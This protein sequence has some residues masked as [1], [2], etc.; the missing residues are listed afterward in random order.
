MALSDNEIIKALEMCGNS[1]G[2]EECPYYDGGHFQNGKCSYN[3]GQDAFNL[4]NRQKAEIENLKTHNA[5]LKMANKLCKGWEERVKAETIKEF[6]ERF[7]NEI[8]ERYEDIAY[9]DLF[10]RV[11][12]NLVKEKVGDNDESTKKS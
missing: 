8:N 4:I 9:K 5:V 6:A 7:K 3:N 2:C 11:V 1:I 12:D 10:F